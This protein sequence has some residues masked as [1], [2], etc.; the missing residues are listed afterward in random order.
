MTPTLPTPLQ[1]RDRDVRSGG[2]GVA[3]R[4]LRGPETILLQDSTAPALGLHLG[5]CVV[6]PVI[7]G[8]VRKPRSHPY[9]LCDLGRVLNILSIQQG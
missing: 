4:P 2:G 3:L 8:K 5:V 1:L 7:K 9:Q 6:R